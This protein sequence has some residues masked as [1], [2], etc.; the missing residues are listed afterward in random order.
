MIPRS[1]LC[2]NSGITRQYSCYNLQ[3][4]ANGHASPHRASLRRRSA[5]PGSRKTYDPGFRWRACLESWPRWARSIFSLRGGW[6]R[7]AL[8]P[9]AGA[10]R[11]SQGNSDLHKLHVE[12]ANALLA[13]GSR[14][15]VPLQDRRPQKSLDMELCRLRL[16]L[17]GRS[18]RLGQPS[19][20]PL[21]YK[22]S[23]GLGLAAID[24]CRF[25]TMEMLQLPGWS[26]IFRICGA[27]GCRMAQRWAKILERG[28]FRGFRLFA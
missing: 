20:A 27:P 6:V 21:A 13:A 11:A 1:T 28:G 8:E 26:S 15:P 14:V 16:L 23:E 18:R 19:H 22:S 17:H 10:F 3:R 9:A 5:V 25:I 7:L 2:C 4:T 12:Y 24:H